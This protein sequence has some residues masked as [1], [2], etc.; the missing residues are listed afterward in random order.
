MNQAF[1]EKNLQF[2]TFQRNVFAAFSIILSVALVLSSTYLFFKTDRIV[3]VPPI[4][5]KSFG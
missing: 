2:L 3:I 1:L 5:E 4:I